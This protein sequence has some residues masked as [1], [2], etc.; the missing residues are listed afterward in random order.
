MAERRAAPRREVTGIERIGAWGEVRYRHQLTC[1]HVEIRKRPAPAPSI[2]CVACAAESKA[3]VLDEALTTRLPEVGLL[4]DD[5]STMAD[6]ET[7]LARTRAG[8]AARFG[9]EA[10]AVDVV[11][12]EAGLAYATVFL[13]AGTIRRLV[14]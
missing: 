1:G 13:D 4:D 10:E 3:R 7:D 8:L 5:W 6:L 2:G 11:A 14:G 9:I 12:T